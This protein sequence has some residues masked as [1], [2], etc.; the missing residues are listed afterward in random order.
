MLFGE[1][2]KLKYYRKSPKTTIFRYCAARTV[3]IV[4][5][6]KITDFYQIKRKTHKNSQ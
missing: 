2:F 3:R 5:A 4:Q 6:R 1:E